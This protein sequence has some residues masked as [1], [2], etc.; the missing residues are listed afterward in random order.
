MMD[1]QWTRPRYLADQSG[2]SIPTKI[3]LSKQFT[4]KHNAT[5]RTTL[6]AAFALNYLDIGN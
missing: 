2:G 3:P 6:Y 1:Q 4:S 5:M